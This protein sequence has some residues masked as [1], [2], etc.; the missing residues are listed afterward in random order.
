MATREAYTIPAAGAFTEIRLAGVAVLVES[1]AFY[2][3]PDEY[4]TIHFDEDS[5]VG[6]P[7]YISSRWSP[8]EPFRRF[9]LQGTAASAGD[10]VW[11]IVIKDPCELELVSL[12]ENSFQRGA[13]EAGATFSRQ[14]T[15]APQSLLAADYT[16]GGAI[17]GALTLATEGADIRLAFGGT[18]PDQAASPTGLIVPDRTSR[19]IVGASFITSLQYISARAGIHATV[20]F[21]TEF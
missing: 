8:Q 9:F 17:A 15:D 19:R 4:P 18:A 13:V 12:N 5:A 16:A 10:I 6:L 11:L 20:N 2:K 3:Q 7:L 1:G 14:S 21:S